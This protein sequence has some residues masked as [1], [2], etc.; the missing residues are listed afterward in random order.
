MRTVF[1]GHR[2]DIK[3]INSEFINRASLS[4]RDRDTIC[5]KRENISSLL[6]VVV[7]ASPDSVRDHCEGHVFSLHERMPTFFEVYQLQSYSKTSSRG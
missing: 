3:I 7:V 4:K 1:R 2:K 5:S 6:A